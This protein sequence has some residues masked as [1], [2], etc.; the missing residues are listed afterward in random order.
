MVVDSFSGHP[1]C[2][3]RDEYVTIYQRYATCAPPALNRIKRYQSQFPHL[4][5]FAALSNRMFHGSDVTLLNLYPAL[6][7]DEMARRQYLSTTCSKI[8]ATLS[9]VAYDKQGGATVYN[10]NLRIPTCPALLL[11][12]RFCG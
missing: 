9:I 10:R 2:V 8:G 4:N 6:E 7:D 1:R 11:K 5:D 12:T 3:Y